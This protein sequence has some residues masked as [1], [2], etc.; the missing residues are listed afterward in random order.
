MDLSRERRCLA[1]DDARQLL[2]FGHGK[3]RMSLQS[4]RTF[5]A[6][7]AV[8]D[9]DDLLAIAQ[10][11][12]PAR[13]GQLGTFGVD[14]RRFREKELVERVHRLDIERTVNVSTFKLVAK[15]TVD[16]VVPLDLVGVFATNEIVHGL[17]CHAD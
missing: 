10:L 7:L 17:G 5:G 4:G 2:D 1:L 15:T 6:K 9:E 3:E 14:A 12:A 8:K 11:A 16:N 13:D